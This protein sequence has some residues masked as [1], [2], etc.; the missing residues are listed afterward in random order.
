MQTYPSGLRVSIRLPVNTSVSEMVAEFTKRAG[1][2]SNSGLELGLNSAVSGP[3]ATASSPA[4]VG[5]TGL[6]T[7]R[8][9]GLVLCALS[10]LVDRLFE[11]AAEE[12]PLPHLLLFSS[13]LMRA[14]AEELFDRTDCLPL[15][16]SLPPSSLA[17]QRP[18]SLAGNTESNSPLSRPMIGRIGAGAGP[19][20]ATSWV[21]QA[22]QSQLGP[23]SRLALGCPAK[24]ASRNAPLLLDR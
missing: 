16:S 12:L 4:A 22:S 21:I 6:L 14:S 9:T 24:L 2:S 15:V 13:H 19:T 11:A 5:S 23:T 18:S 20:L 10:Q 1:S 3:A 17:S 7:V 8:Q